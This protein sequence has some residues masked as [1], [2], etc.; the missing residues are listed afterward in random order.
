MDAAAILTR[1]LPIRIALISFS[2]LSSNERARRAPLCPWLAMCFRR[3]RFKDIIPVSELEKNAE[4]SYPEFCPDTLGYAAWIEEIWLNY[5]S[6][7][8]KYGG[9]PP[10]IEIGY[11]LLENSTIKHIAVAN[12]KTWAFPIK[13]VPIRPTLMTVNFSLSAKVFYSEKLPEKF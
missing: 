3:Y 6:N 10:K 2:G 8:I 9:T 7:A 12:P 11:D 1:L 5:L 4:I 13:P